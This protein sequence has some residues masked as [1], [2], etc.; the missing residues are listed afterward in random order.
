[1]LICEC[2]ADLY[3]NAFLHQVDWTLPGRSYPNLEEMPSFIAQQRQ[4]GIQRI[5]TTNANPQQLQGKQLLVYT[6]VCQHFE[7]H[8]PLPLR[9]IVSGTAGTGKSYVINC[10]RLLLKEKLRVGAPTGVA[11]FNVEGHTLLSLFCLPTKSEYKDL[12]GD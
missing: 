8:N 3:N 9:M 2:H 10:L 7:S 6:A 4:L 1:M 5:F 11:A 12:Q